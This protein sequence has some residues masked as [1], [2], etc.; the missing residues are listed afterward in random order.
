MN[1]IQYDNKNI[2]L[3]E[4]NNQCKHKEN[5]LVIN[6]EDN[7]GIVVLNKELLEKMA[8]SSFLS[9]GIEDI[10]NDNLVDGAT[11]FGD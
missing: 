3:T 8:L 11:F 9:S 2:T 1:L 7:N 5:I 6:D 10:K 4:I